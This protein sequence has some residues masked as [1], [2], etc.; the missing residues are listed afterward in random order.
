MGVKIK[1]LTPYAVNIRDLEEKKFEN[2]RKRELMNGIR[3]DTL[4]EVLISKSQQDL[5]D[6]KSTLLQPPNP[7]KARLDFVK[8][9]TKN[10][11][12]VSVSPIY[13]Q[14]SMDDLYIVQ[15]LSNKVTSEFLEV[16]NLWKQYNEASVQTAADKKRK[17]EQDI[18]TELILDFICD[19]GADIV[20]IN[21]ERGNFVPLI[22]LS[23][24]TITFAQNSGL[25][26]QDRS[27]GNCETRAAIFYYNAQIG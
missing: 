5:L 7:K 10:T 22:L 9:K 24:S 15:Q 25:E 23:A 21:E 4:M 1:D 13:A 2:S 14:V 3:C 26:E 6:R 11:T 18:P 19:K 20:I 12:E 16:G 8:F 27:E 17:M